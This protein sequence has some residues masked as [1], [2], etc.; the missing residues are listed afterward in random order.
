VNRV[1]LALALLGLSACS[2]TTAEQRRDIAIQTALDSARAA[3][4]VLQSDRS[5]EREPGMDEWC[6]GVLHGCAK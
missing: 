2:T 6:Q 5:I 3:C 4:L 1:A